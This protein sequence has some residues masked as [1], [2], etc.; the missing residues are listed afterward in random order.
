MKTT[1]SLL[2]SIICAA[3]LVAAAPF[4]IAQRADSKPNTNNNTKV[5][6]LL[7]S[8]FVSHQS[9]AVY[10]INNEPSG[11][12]IIVG[13]IQSNGAVVP[14]RAVLTGGKGARVQVDQAGPN[15]LFSQG[16]VKASTQSKK[17]AAVNPGDNTVS[18]FSVD[19]KNPVNINLIGSPQNTGGEFPVSLA[20]NKDGKTLCVLNGGKSSGV[21]CFKVEDKGL[22]AIK[23]TQR[24]LN[25]NQTTPAKGPSN[26][27]S[28]IMFNENN[29]KLI[30]SIK[31][32]STSS[33]GY[34]AVFDVAKDGSLSS[35]YTTVKPPAGGSLPVA[36]RNIPGRNAVLA[37]DAGTGMAVF[38]FSTIKNV[39]EKGNQTSTKNTLMS[40]NGQKHMG[41]VTYS[42]KTKSFFM[43][44]AGTSTITEVTVD[45]NLKGKVVK[46]YPQHDG[47]ATLDNAI[48]TINNQDFLYVLNA[49]T[50][51]IGAMQL[52]KQGNAVS[53][54]SF[55]FGNAAK[56]ANVQL[57]TN[58]VQGMATFNKQ[59]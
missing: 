12:S 51:S 6:N 48:A 11:N 42:G 14:N 49:G 7:P 46:Q 9:G 40:V 21:N 15:A 47:T 4:E 2:V 36:L 26:T 17:L 33:P 28:S 34:L 39:K 50:S 58:N 32:S 59:R 19:P 38:D 52:S 44:D 25:L 57:N 10:F 43:T 31:G 37:T 13:E 23:D 45:K 20:F 55:D 1:F 54:G 53:L 30:A 8:N 22:Q 41:W 16:A 56:R 27:A 29:T 3:T 18:L 24:S 35:N 5:T